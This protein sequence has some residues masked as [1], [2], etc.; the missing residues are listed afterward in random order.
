MDLKL[1]IPGPV[2]V[3][4]DV[5]EQMSKPMIGH[6]SQAY[7]DLHASTVSNLKKLFY[8]ENMVFLGTNSSTGWMEAAVRNCVEEKSLHGVNGAF[9]KRWHQIAA[10]CAKTPEKI[11]VEW[12][13]AV[14]PGQVEEKLSSGD[15]EAFFVTHNETSTAVMTPLEELGKICAENDVLFC[16]DAVSSAAGVKIDVDELGID[17][18]VT[19]T[20]KALAVAPGLSM[21]VVSRKALDKSKGMEDKGHYFDYMV[22]EKKAGKDNTPTTPA[23]PQIYAL[24]YQLKKILG[25]EGVDERYER[26]RR[27]AEHTRGWVKKHWGM[28]AEDWCASDTVTCAKNTLEVDLAGLSEKLLDRG[29]L[30]SNGYGS[31]KG[32]A[33]RVAHMG[34]RKMSD[35][36]EYLDLIQELAGI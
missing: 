27:M 24:D 13:S 21:T 32:K 12:G 33:F 30:L 34:D 23:I 7:K 5:A 10:A 35:L 3:S 18:L 17:V 4:E 28:Y 14:K 9:S 20:Q 6:R 26:H 2:D 8:T 25:E 16:V 22:F 11:E 19:G 36:K 31:L 1:F 15:Y 29:F